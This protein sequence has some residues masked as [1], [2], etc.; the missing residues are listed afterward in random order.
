LRLE[1]VLGVAGGGTIAQLTE[2]PA[3]RAISFKFEKTKGTVRGFGLNRVFCI[4]LEF[5]KGAGL[6]VLYL[7]AKGVTYH[8]Y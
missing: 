8:R 6:G 3:L 5:F 7:T 2:W 4:F 1:R